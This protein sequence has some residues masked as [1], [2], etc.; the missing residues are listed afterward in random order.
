MVLW[1]PKQKSLLWTKRVANPG[2]A[3]AADVAAAAAA[4]LRRQ[5]GRQESLVEEASVR[6]HVEVVQ[7]ESRESRKQ[8]GLFWTEKSKSV[9]RWHPWQRNRVAIQLEAA[10]CRCRDCSGLVYV[11]ITASLA[12]PPKGAVVVGF[13]LFFF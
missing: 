13:C 6:L 12:P 1:Y 4:V 3:E 11:C 5:Q 2:A 7:P 10:C 9:K 8:A